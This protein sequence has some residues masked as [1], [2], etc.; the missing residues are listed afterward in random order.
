MDSK[1]ILHRLLIFMDLVAPTGSASGMGGD[2]LTDLHGVGGQDLNT[3]HGVDLARCLD[4]P[5]NF[6]LKKH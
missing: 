3:E 6:Q 5:Q 1:M 2:F 4:L